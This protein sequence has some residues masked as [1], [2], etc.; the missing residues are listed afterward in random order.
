MHQHDYMVLSVINGEALRFDEVVARSGVSE[1]DAKVSLNVLHLSKRIER[2][3]QGNQM[4]FR[5]R[6]AMALDDGGVR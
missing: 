1:H 3:F 5:R 6:G 4:L 2:V